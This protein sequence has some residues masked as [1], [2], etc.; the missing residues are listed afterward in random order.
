MTHLE[1]TEKLDSFYIRTGSNKVD[2]GIVLTA[3]KYYIHP[4]YNLS[5][6]SGPYDL[7]LVYVKRRYKKTAKNSK[8]VGI[9]LPEKN[10]ENDESEIAYYS[11]F[12]RINYKGLRATY[13]MK[14]E[15]TLLPDN[16]CLAH[17]SK[18]NMACLKSSSSHTCKVKMLVEAG[19]E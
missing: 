2:A 3:H 12:G 7:A 6:L 16:K 5:D 1:S 19:E 13:L 18:N 14:S 9:C 8:V 11:G 4:N 15:M 17:I 10:I